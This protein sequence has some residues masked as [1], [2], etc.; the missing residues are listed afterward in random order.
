MPC[1]Y[2]IIIRWFWQLSSGVVFVLIPLY[3]VVKDIL[4]DFVQIGFVA[5]DVFII[6]TL[7]EA[8]PR[9][10]AKGIDAFGGE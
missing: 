3:R 10:V 4:A 5:D 6:V 2:H 7:P 9:G 1:P 8:V